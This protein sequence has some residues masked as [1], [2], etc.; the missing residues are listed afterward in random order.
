MNVLF[1]QKNETHAIISKFKHKKLDSI[2]YLINKEKSFFTKEIFK[3]RLEYLLTGKLD[4]LNLNANLSNFICLDSIIYYN[5]LA[6]YYSNKIN[7]NDSLVFIFSSK[8]LQI[9]KKQKDTLLINESLRIIN[10]LFLKNSTDLKLNKQYIAGLLTYKKDKIDGFWYQYYYAMYQLSFPLKSKESILKTKREFLKLEQITPKIS[11][12]QSISNHGIGIFYHSINQSKTARTYFTKALLGEED[13]YYSYSRKVRTLIGLAVMDYKEEK[14]DSA[15]IKLKKT[16]QSKY[17]KTDYE[18]K[19]L[20]Y[21]WIYKSYK[22]K[23]RIDSSHYYLELKI[24][25]KDSVK[26]YQ[27]AEKI[28]SIDIKFKVKEINKNLKNQITKMNTIL[29]ILGIITL[30][31]GVVFFLYKKYAKKTIVLE[32]EKLETLQKLDELKDVVIK[33]HIV[34]KDKTKIYVADLLYIKSDDHFIKLFLSTGKNHFVRGKLS[35]IIQELPPN[36]I[37][38]HR[39]YVINRN[40]VKQINN[41]FIILTDK[42]E[43]PLSRTYKDK[44]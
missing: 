17:V 36:F 41:T 7:P 30:L 1:A 43:I 12:F 21:D 42:T 31:L 34:L 3:N 28:R 40:F 23:K 19:Y 9:S 25:A 5:H 22:N 27:F 13:K 16:L 37:R 35:Q 38:T 26:Y 44:L 18:L 6:H 4:T 11:Y 2:N 14:Y 15:I 33:N 32:E 20:I 8:A 39:S 29:P 24:K 10:K